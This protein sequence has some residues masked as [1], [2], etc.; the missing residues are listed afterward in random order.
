MRKAGFLRRPSAVWTVPSRDVSSEA[1]PIADRAAKLLETRKLIWKVDLTLV[2]VLVVTHV[3]LKF[4]VPEFPAAG[5]LGTEIGVLEAATVVITRRMK[6]KEK[7]L[8]R[9]Y[10]EQTESDL[11]P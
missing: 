1:A 7:E 8:E 6:K 5:Y 3:S 10:S 11:S 4:L 2:A 9:E